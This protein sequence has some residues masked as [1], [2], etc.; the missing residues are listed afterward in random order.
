[1]ISV[2]YFPTISLEVNEGGKGSNMFKGIIDTVS[3]WTKML[4]NVGAFKDEEKRKGCSVSDEVSMQ[5][6]L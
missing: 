5:N 1:M 3:R 6:S 2:K 4:E